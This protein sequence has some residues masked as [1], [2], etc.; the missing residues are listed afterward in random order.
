[1]NTHSHQFVE[2]YNG[3]LGF[4]LDRNTDEATVVCYLQ[5]FSDDALMQIMIERLSD[6]NLS[7]IFELI[8]RMLKMHLTESEYHRL[9]LKDAHPDK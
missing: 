7:E 3:L 1:M 6:E 2:T 9:F 4:G 5:K 8:T